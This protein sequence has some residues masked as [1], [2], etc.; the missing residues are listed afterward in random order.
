M[1]EQEAREIIQQEQLT[2]RINWYDEEVLKENQVGIR[3]AREGWEVYITGE[4]AEVI[5]GT[6]FWFE[7]SDDAYEA[8]IRKAR[9]VKKI[10]G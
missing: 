5:N 2:R 8:L 7:N 10:F 9:Y 3:K 1:K 6:E 4:R